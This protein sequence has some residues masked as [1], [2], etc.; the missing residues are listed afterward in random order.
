MAEGI[1]GP[2]DATPVQPAPGSDSPRPSNTR[3]TGAPPCAW[4]QSGVPAVE[5]DALHRSEPSPA[6]E[7]RLSTVG[8]RLRPAMVMFSVA[9]DKGV[10]AS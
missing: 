2:R 9:G 8:D 10:P 5:P 4:A 6:E 7:L 1:L 3:R